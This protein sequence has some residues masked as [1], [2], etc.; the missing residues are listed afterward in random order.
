MGRKE[1]EWDPF[2]VYYNT[3]SK[4]FNGDSAYILGIYNSSL[5]WNHTLKNPMLVIKQGKFKFSKTEREENTNW[6]VGNKMQ[7]DDFLLEGQEHKTHKNNCLAAHSHLCFGVDLF[8]VHDHKTE[9]LLFQQILMILLP[10]IF[11]PC[12]ESV[13]FFIRNT[14]TP[15]NSSY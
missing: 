14:D 2:D 5:C 8:R 13:H 9:R 10:E 15:Y 4:P 11:L 1:D 3:R 7:I 6:T 12:L